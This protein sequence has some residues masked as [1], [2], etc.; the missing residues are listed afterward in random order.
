M[1]ENLDNQKVRARDLEIDLGGVAKTLWNGR[2]YLAVSVLIFF[3][4][5][6]LS[7]HFSQKKYTASLI[8]SP[9]IS[10][11]GLSGVSGFGGLADMVGI[12]IGSG[13]NLNFTKYFAYLQSDT[14]AMSLLENSAV[15]KKVFAEDWDEKQGAWQSNSTLSRLPK[16]IL[17][18][19]VG[20]PYETAPNITRVSSFLKDEVWTSK[21]PDS[22]MIRISFTHSDPDFARDFLLILHR[23]A[24]LIVR[25]SIEQRTKSRIAYLNAAIPLV[26]VVDQ[27]IAMVDLLSIEEQNLMMTKADEH[28]AAEIVEAPVAPNIFSTP[29]IGLRLGLS[30]LLGLLTGCV[31]AMIVEKQKA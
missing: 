2:R 5:A 21:V 26:N 10:Q 12:D 27:R 6:M 19:L 23:E 15:L 13:E 28:F 22:S 25:S 30:V 16:S 11:S 17:F 24:D 3:L 9:T 31:W 18:R 4:V 7:I 14:I 1:T 8:V 29:N 20:L